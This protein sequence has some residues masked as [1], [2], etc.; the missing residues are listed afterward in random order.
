MPTAVGSFVSDWMQ[1]LRLVDAVEARLLAL[2]HDALQVGAVGQAQF[3]RLGMNSLR[4][5]GSV[6][7]HLALLVAQL[8]RPLTVSGAATW[9]HRGRASGASFRD[10][11]A[12]V[13]AGAG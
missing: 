8:A 3:Q 4:P 7:G 9:P 13:V 2:P 5:L 10:C 6:S 1:P 12:G 11:A